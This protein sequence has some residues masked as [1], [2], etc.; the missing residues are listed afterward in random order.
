MPWPEDGGEYGD[1]TLADHYRKLGSLRRQYKDLLFHGSL[2]FTGSEGSLLSFQRS[3]E[4]GLIQ[5][6][7]N[8]SSQPLSLPEGW[9]EGEFLELYR[10]EKVSIQGEIVLDPYGF[11]IL[12]DF[13][14]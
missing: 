1:W 7:I 3:G 10:N 2:E 8:L 11:M 6:L 14:Q 13:L 5:V 4:Q 9:L 12:G